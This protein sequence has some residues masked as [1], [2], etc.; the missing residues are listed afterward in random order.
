MNVALLQGMNIVDNIKSIVEKLISKSRDN[1]ITEDDFFSV[2]D[3][4]NISF[5][6]IPGIYA[7]LSS[8]GVDI[9]SDEELIK[10]QVIH[11][12]SERRKLYLKEQEN[13]QKE[14][15]DLIKKRF[16]SDYKRSRCQSSYMPVTMLGMFECSDSKGK[17]L[18]SDLVVFFKEF[19]ENRKKQNLI[20][21]RSDSI[22]YKTS[23]ADKEIKKLILFNPLGRSCLVKYFRY[24]EEK[25]C[26]FFN[27]N[28]W[29]SFSIADMKNIIQQ[30]KDILYDYYEKLS[31][32]QK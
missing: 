22:F 26:L 30:S 12:V 3:D 27:E 17:V 24:D 11:N 8:Q 23:P 21:E 18:I 29:N 9:A 28:L 14:S 2:I 5:D 1:Y 6:Q 4:N 13:Y 32:R 15:G 16:F 19:Y 25:E 7:M 31:Q 10:K 20:V